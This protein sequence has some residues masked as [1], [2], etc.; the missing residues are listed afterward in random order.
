MATPFSGFRIV[1]WYRGDVWTYG[2]ARAAIETK[3]GG[4]YQDVRGHVLVYTAVDVSDFPIVRC[5]L[6]DTGAIS[7]CPN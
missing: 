1:Y 6:V 4:I 2:A 5:D 7:Y 3:R